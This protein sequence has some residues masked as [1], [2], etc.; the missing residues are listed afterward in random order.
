[1]CNVRLSI[2]A[3]FYIQIYKKNSF[4]TMPSTFMALFYIFKW[5]FHIVNYILKGQR[6]TFHQISALPFECVH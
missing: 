2:D 6:F 1:M 3:K 5:A 4:I